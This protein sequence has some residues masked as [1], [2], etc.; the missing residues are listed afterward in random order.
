MKARKH[1]LKLVAFDEQTGIA[2]YQCRKC[3][4]KIERKAMFLCGENQNESI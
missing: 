1:S 3:G 2:I 4:Q